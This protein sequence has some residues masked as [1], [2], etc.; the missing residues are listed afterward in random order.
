MRSLSIKTVVRRLWRMVHR[1]VPRCTSPY[2]DKADDEAVTRRR[3]RD[4]SVDR[5]PRRHL[6]G[7]A[8]VFGAR[9]QHRLYVRAHAGSRV[10]AFDA[11]GTSRMSS[12]VQCLEGAS[13]TFR[14]VSVHIW[15][16]RSLRRR[17]IGDERRR[18]SSNHHSS[19]ERR[20]FG[21]RA[22]V[23]VPADDTGFDFIVAPISSVAGDGR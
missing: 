11:L 2:D 19:A 3:D 18:P 12:R 14:R 17:K 8:E 22:R 5:G 10:E 16:R 21:G 1:R 6:D 23:S 4:K 13:S 9:V 15:R 7:D 20:T